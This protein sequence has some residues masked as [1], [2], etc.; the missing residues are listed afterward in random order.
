MK[1]RWLMLLCT[2]VSLSAS[3][4]IFAQLPGPRLPLFGVRDHQQGEIILRI[5]YEIQ[6]EP[7]RRLWHLQAIDNTPPIVTAGPPII[8]PGMGSQGVFLSGGRPC[9][10]EDTACGSGCG[11]LGYLC[12]DKFCFSSTSVPVFE[13]RRLADLVVSPAEV[14]LLWPARNTALRGAIVRAE[15]ISASGDRQELP[16]KSAAPLPAWLSDILPATF[17]E[18]PVRGRDEGKPFPGYEF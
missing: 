15:L 2:S 13:T 5:S 3:S 14:G 1:Y 10:F 17:I 12:E 11:E 9:C 6:E 7:E 8:I 16:L 18:R 4:P